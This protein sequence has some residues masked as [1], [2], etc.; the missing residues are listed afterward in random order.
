MTHR[1]HP[2]QSRSGEN[3]FH[4]QPREPHP[5]SA[6]RISP[7]RHN[8]HEHPLMQLPALNQLARNLV[9]VDK[10]R[11]VSPDTTAHSAFSTA[12]ESP[13][14]RSIDEIF[15]RMEEPGSWIALYNVEQDPVYR[16]FLLEVT[17]DLRG[18]VEAT[19]P[20]M[21]TVQG[22]IFISAPPSVTPFHIDRENN[23]WLQI[24]GRKVITLWDREDRLAVPQLGAEE[25][26]VE[27]NL[28]H[29]RLDD[30]VQARGTEHDVGPG[31]GIYFPSTTPHMTRSGRDWCTPGDGVSISIGV[32]F[33]TAT[34][35]RHAHIHTCNAI[36]RRA[37]LSPRAPGHSPLDG[38]KAF[39]GGAAVQLKKRLRGFTPPP[40]F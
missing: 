16:Q 23:F 36:L 40:G 33:Y 37:G 30:A 12:G 32:V 11:F 13:D 7:I 22:F 21:H 38:F 4:I 29:V 14:G 19:Q 20:G 1:Q 28:R 24:R 31:D 6:D 5:F 25:F 18:L 2:V 35:R 10:C 34:T 15:A 3:G 26:I 8:Y 9:A 39:L 17:A 27:H